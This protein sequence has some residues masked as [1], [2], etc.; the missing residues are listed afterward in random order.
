MVE[1][2]FPFIKNLSSGKDTAFAKYI[3]DAIF[4]IPNAHVLSRVIT[5]LDI[6]DL[7]DKDT[8]GDVYETLLSELQQSGKDGQFR[9]PR[10]IIDMMV[11]LM[12]PRLTDKICDPAMGSAG[13]I[14]SSA[15]FISDNYKTQLMNQETNKYFNEEMFSG[16]DM[17][18]T[19]L[20]IG[21]MNMMLHGVV[22]HTV[23]ATTRPRPN[24]STSL[25]FSLRPSFLC[26]NTLM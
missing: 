20:R 11:Q 13:F 16:F 24:C 5:A 26:L 22:M 1:K 8:M 23:M 25:P 12:R 19:M 2:V 10:H 21:A 7:N 3:K 6:L 15:R 17:D 14:S 18:Q 4:L 9:T